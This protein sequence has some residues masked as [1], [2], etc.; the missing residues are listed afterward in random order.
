[1]AAT[2]SHRTDES[3][4]AIL[5]RRMTVS[6]VLFVYL[7]TFIYF[8]FLLASP[9]S[10]SYLPT[11]SSKPQSF[12]LDLKSFTRFISKLQNRDGK[13]MSKFIT[14]VLNSLNGFVVKID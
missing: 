8:F 3:Q 9:F 10:G 4:H 12:V 11:P 2:N 1:M 6:P 5:R 14:V 13:L 7:F